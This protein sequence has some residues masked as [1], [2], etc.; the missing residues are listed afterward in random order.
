MIVFEQGVFSIPFRFPIRC[1][2]LDCCTYKYCGGAEVSR[3][4]DPP[5]RAERPT[6][7]VTVTGADFT[8]I[9]FA[10]IIHFLPE[11]GEHQMRIRSY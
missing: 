8:F 10:E 5:T 11:S 1:N 7:H 3:H 4:S 2:K 9:A 6:G